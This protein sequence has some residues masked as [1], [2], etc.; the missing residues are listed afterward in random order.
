EA[1]K[2]KETAA[3]A[4]LSA[5]QQA[6]FQKIAK[7]IPESDPDARL[8]L[9]EMLLDGRLLKSK[10][11]RGGNDLLSNL[12]KLSDGPMQADLAKEGGKLLGDLIQEVY[13]PTCI[14]QG[15]KGTCGATTV[16]ILLAKQNP[17]DYARLISGLASPSGKAILASGAE[18]SRQAGTEKDDKSCRTLATRLM[19]PAFMQYGNGIFGYS[20]EKD[21]TNYHI[22]KAGGLMNGQFDGL[23]EA[24]LKKD[25]K[26]VIVGV[27]SPAHSVLNDIAKIATPDNPVPI[28]LTYGGN[29][30]VN[31]GHFVQITGIKDGKATFVNPWGRV[32]SL[33]QADLEKHIMSAFI[34]NQR[35][36][37]LGTGSNLVNGVGPAIGIVGELAGGFLDKVKKWWKK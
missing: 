23:A 28:S 32:E 33:S 11:L 31:D 36:G 10:D 25:Y 5:S 1:N 13:D 4:K 7:A 26:A 6:Q 9:Q 21:E 30:L 24:A 15:S 3:L 12:S 18:I 27:T 35:E 29:R 16:Q 22:V 14:S 8:C 2:P 19:A 37:L 34:P 20:N 17:A